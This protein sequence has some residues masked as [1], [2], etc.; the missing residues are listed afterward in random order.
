MNS[1]NKIF[2][3]LTLCGGLLFNLIFWHEILALN[4][5]I[6]DAF[7][8]TSVVYLYP[9]TKRS[10]N[11]YLFLLIHLVCLTTLILHNTDLSKILWMLTLMLTVAFAQY[12]HRSVWFAG[13]AAILSVAVF[14]SNFR[15]TLDNSG[16]GQKKRFQVGKLIRFLFF[17]GMIVF[18]FFVIYTSGNSIFRAQ[19]ESLTIPVKNA[20]IYIFGQVSFQRI[21]FF[22]FGTYL[23]GALL[24]RARNQSLESKEAKFQDGL[25][26][27]QLKK[28]D[29]RKTFVFGFVAAIMGKLA[30]GP[31]GLKNENKVGILSL[32]FL[33]L[34]LV[35]VNAIDIQYLWFN[36]QPSAE[37]N[38]MHL[39]HEGTGTLILSIVL[40]IFVVMFFFRGNLNF[41]KNNKWLLFGAYFW[42]LQNIILVFSV[43]LRD[44]YYIREMGFAYKRLGVLF[45]LLLVLSGLVTVFLKIWLKRSNY[46][47]LRVNA[48]I[49]IV[50]MTIGSMIDWDS[51]IARYNIAHHKTIP[52]DVAF[53][54]KLSDNAIPILQEN[55][56][57]LENREAELNAKKIYPFRHAGFLPLLMNEKVGSFLA[58][59]QEETW[60]SWNKADADVLRYLEGR[61]T[62]SKN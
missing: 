1:R 11:F 40:A 37:I 33:N 17:P 59:K 8:L 4:A 47:L 26:R 15:R 55:I 13:G 18:A 43:G 46:F 45:W 30:R 62:Y 10:P 54:L 27:A 3:V 5:L 29:N 49:V 56:E 19:I 42:L 16:A 35:I 25:S 14:A 51:L 53:L 7:V 21:V 2:V 41:Y 34:L 48:L 32:F 52:L 38:L 12:V 31:L 61:G 23:T 28:R 22:F 9:K 50:F 57:V 44:Y 58:R 20:L 39:V 24:L 60:L 6:F 36:F